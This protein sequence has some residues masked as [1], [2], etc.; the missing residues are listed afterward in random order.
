MSC[1]SLPFMF[2]SYHVFQNK[3]KPLMATS[4]L[5]TITQKLWLISFEFIVSKLQPRREIVTK[6][7]YV[8]RHGTKIY[9][10]RSYTFQ[11]TRVQLYFNF[12]GYVTLHSLQR[13][14]NIVHYWWKFFFVKMH[15]S[16][17]SCFDNHETAWNNF[18]LWELWMKHERINYER[19]M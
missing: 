8:V 15:C 1:V 5:I 11:R 18:T 9:A 12:I 4:R 7:C 10:E 3:H 2:I 19:F 13:W 6:Y 17:Q 16:F 14:L